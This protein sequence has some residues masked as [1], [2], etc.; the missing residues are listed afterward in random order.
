MTCCWV[1]I[2]QRVGYELIEK[3][4]RNVRAWVRIVWVRKIHGYETTGYRLKI[5]HIG[6]LTKVSHDWLATLWEYN[7]TNNRNNAPIP[8]TIAAAT[9]IKQ[10]Q[11][12]TAA[13]LHCTVNYFKTLYPVLPR[14]SLARCVDVFLE[15]L[16]MFGLVSFPFKAKENLQR[17]GDV[18]FDILITSKGVSAL[19]VFETLI[20]V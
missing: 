16:F 13:T 20:G 10:K 18:F 11:L 17:C 14:I 4:V 3:W 5:P 7:R 19:G 6:P 2:N 1:R 12:W 9:M 15:V 8:N